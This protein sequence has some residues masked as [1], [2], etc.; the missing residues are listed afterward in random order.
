M[1][2]EAASDRL[3]YVLERPIAGEPGVKWTYCG[4]ATALLGRLIATGV[5][6]TLLD[7]S[8]HVLFD[9]LGFGPAEWTKA[10]DGE[11]RADSGLRLLPRDLL[12]LG[13]LMLAGGSWNGRRIVPAEWVTRITTPVIA[14]DGARHYGYHWYLGEFPT[15]ASPQPLRWIGG[16]GWGGQYLLAIVK[17]DL[18][19]A[20]NCG[21]YHKPL[22]EQNAIPRTVLGEVV[23]P[24]LL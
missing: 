8:R 12:K 20:I 15:G 17:L 5:G 22:T 7:Y 24:S 13:Q 9:P 3:R 4:G 23:L 10:H 11:A 18:A 16:I 2:M 1:M 19:I 14:I 21:N 6:Q